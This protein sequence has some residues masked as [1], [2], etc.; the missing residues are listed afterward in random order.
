MRRDGH[1]VACEPVN[2]AASALKHLADDRRD[3][4]LPLR[5]LCIA[6]RT[7]WTA[8]AVE[9]VAPHCERWLRER[10]GIDS[11]GEQ[12]L[13]RAAAVLALDLQAGASAEAA[14]WF[15]ALRLPAL[16][17]FRYPAFDEALGTQSGL[18]A[19]TV[20]RSVAGKRLA[21]Y[22]QFR[23]GLARALAT[24]GERLQPVRPNE[25]SQKLVLAALARGIPVTRITRQMAAYRLGTGCRQQRLW[26]GF[27]GATSHL[28]T[29]LTTHKEM[30]NEVLR[31]NGFPVP[32]QRVVR[33]AQAAQQAAEAIGY[34]VVVKPSST[35]Y[36]TAVSTGLR[37]AAA[38]LRAFEVA[39]KHGN[40]LIGGRCIGV[41]RRE[42][43]RVAGNG[44]DTVA[45]LMGQL[46][47]RRREDAVMRRFAAATPDD[48]LVMQMLRNQGLAP[49]DVPAEGRVVQ[50]RSNSNLSTGGIC[51]DVT[52]EAHPDNLQLAERVAECVGL[53]HAGIDFITPDIGRSWHD[54]G[55]AI[56]EVNP[57][58]AFTTADAHEHLL[59]HLF[60]GGGTGC[61]PI[62]LLV[63]EAGELR[64]CVERI[65]ALCAGQAR[66]G[67]FAIAGEAKVGAT[68]ISPSAYPVARLAA[69]VLADPRAE[70][71][72]VANGTAEVDLPYL[73]ATVMASHADRIAQ[74]CSALGLRDA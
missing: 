71:L 39:R 20:L 52:R 16:E 33:E 66:R 69:M 41:V 53:D 59:D 21:Q 50:L 73:D 67:G 65:E 31:E 40:V 12:A 43:P 1:A 22:E 23:E 63:G 57:T 24:A 51:V 46:A 49:G 68:R 7:S 6:W 32:R 25:S 28:A 74:L 13:D 34:P 15:A 27:T 60:P 72:L 64:E 19:F 29:I 3:A 11:E 55:G 38:V 18:A 62:V 36:G 47:A 4:G 9:A 54:A 17:G 35:D 45:Q 2:A 37:D 70:F 44:R 30:T 58:P 26:R 10:L 14:E 5:V 48:P 8:E 61:V 42:P 56:C